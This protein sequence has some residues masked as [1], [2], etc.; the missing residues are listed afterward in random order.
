MRVMDLKTY[1]RSLPSEA[2]RSA[3]AVAC[4][5]TIGHLKNCVYVADKWPA[6][7]LCVAL[8]RQSRGSMT[9][10]EL[11]P[12]WADIWP[13]LKSRKARLEKAAA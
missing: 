11:R 10:A 8:E 13:E 6:P 7:A 2:A 1:L 3:F 5:T 4:G 12:D 9:R